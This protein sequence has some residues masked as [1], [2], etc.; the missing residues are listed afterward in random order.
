MPLLVRQCQRHP[1]R[2]AIAVCVV[3]S[4]PICAECSTTYEGVNYS[5]E[6]LEQYLASRRAS[7]TAGRQ[8]GSVLS[9]LLWIVSPLAIYLAW[10]G[11]EQLGQLTVDLIQSSRSGGEL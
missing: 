10:L 9:V 1:D 2:K 6:G 5:K 8:R 7:S 11:L 4:V 3:T